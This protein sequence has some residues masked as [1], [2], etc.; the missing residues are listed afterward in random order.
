MDQRYRFFSTG[1]HLGETGAKA[2]YKDRDMAAWGTE[3]FFFYDP[4]LVCDQNLVERCGTNRL[5]NIFPLV[6]HR[7][8]QGLRLSQAKRFIYWHRAE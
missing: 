2:R 6:T 7:H 5:Y 3:P 8:R 4:E 1:S